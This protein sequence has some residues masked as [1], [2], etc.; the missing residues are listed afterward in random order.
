MAVTPPV[1][2]CDICRNIISGDVTPPVNG[3]AQKGRRGCS[4]AIVLH[5]VGE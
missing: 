1:D 3:A 2:G 5:A 4:S